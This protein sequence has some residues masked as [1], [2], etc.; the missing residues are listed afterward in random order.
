MKKFFSIGETAK[1]NNISIQ[2]LRLYDRM[3]LLKPSYINKDNGYRYYSIDQFIYIDIIKYAKTY[4]I[5]LH[6]LKP[7]LAMGDMKEIVEKIRIF[8][9][10]L[11]EQIQSLIVAKERFSRIAEAIE[12]GLSVVQNQAPYFRKVEE[13]IIIHLIKQQEVINFEVNGRLVENETSRTGVELAFESGY[14]VDIPSLIIDGEEK[15]SSAYLAINEKYSNRPTLLNS[16]YIVSSIPKGEFI[17]ITYNKQNKDNQIKQLQRHIK[18]L[19]IEEI[20]LIIACELYDDF[21]NPSIELQV[22]QGEY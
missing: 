10:S 1:I 5:P 21:E 18:E 16:D 17:C 4:G 6:E 8:Q 9:H 19:N 15:Y 7:T 11:D 20:K 3:G 12:Y 22:L 13:R 2:A 14:F